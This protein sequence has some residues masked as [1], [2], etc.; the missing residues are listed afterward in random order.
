MNT[1]IPVP[2]LSRLSASTAVASRSGACSRLNVA[3]TAAGSVAA[4]IA[5]TMNAEVKPRPVVAWRTSPTTKAT[6]STAGDGQE[7]DADEGRTELGQVDP[8]GR[9]EDQAGQEHGQHQVRR[10]RDAGARMDDSDRQAKQDQADCVRQ[11]DPFRDQGDEHG[12][13]QQG[14]DDPVGGEGQVGSHGREYG[15]PRTARIELG[16]GPI[17]ARSGRRITTPPVTAEC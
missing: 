7:Q 15:P 1:T 12:R 6:I 10:D 11:P 16:I 9:L 4:T 13:R 3:I 17:Q 14:D 2:S 8:E 5:P